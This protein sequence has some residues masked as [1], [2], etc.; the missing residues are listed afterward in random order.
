MPTIKPTPPSIIT[1]GII[2]L[3]DA[4]EVLP[5]KL[6]TKKPSTTPYMDI[7]TIIATDGSTNLKSRPA[8]K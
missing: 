7:N 2:R 1:N 4:K 6:D 8:V 3:I 5:A